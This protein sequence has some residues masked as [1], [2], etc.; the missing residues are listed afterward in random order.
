MKKAIQTMFVLAILF[1]LVTG[2]Y[3]Y[4]QTKPAGNNTTSTTGSTA[5]KATTPRPAAPA[6]AASHAAAACGDKS[7]RYF[8]CGNGTVTDSVTG[9]IWLKNAACFQSMNWDA[10][11]KAAAEL[12]SGDCMLND[13]SAAGDWRL[14]TRE[15]WEETIKNATSLGCGPALTNDEGTKCLDQGP[16]SFTG[17]ERDYYWSSTVYEG[18]PRAYFGDLD[19]GHLLNG[20]FTG[21]LRVWPVRGGAAKK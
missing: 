11:K 13:G 14:P 6:A 8:D 20:V 12:K 16:S 9:L 2:I 1:G 4:A 7:K 17:V 19:H 3:A 5:T 21:N 15:E 18:S 10:A